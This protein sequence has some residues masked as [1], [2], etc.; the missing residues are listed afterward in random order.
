MS[1]ALENLEFTMYGPS[2][3]SISQKQTRTQKVTAGRYPSFFLLFFVSEVNVA[4]YKLNLC[5]FQLYITGTKKAC[6]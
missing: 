5:I 4:F 1:F 3:S 6:K 2:V